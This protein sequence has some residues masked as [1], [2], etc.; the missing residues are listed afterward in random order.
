MIR[1]LYIIFN[2]RL[3]VVE[4]WVILI[5]C[6]IFYSLVLLTFSVVLMHDDNND[7]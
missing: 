1:S 3:Q 7:F 2:S 4:F 6:F 5:E